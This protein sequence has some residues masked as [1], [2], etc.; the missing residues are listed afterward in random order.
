MVRVL[1]LEDDETFADLLRL[2]LEARG[3]SAEIVHS[4]E[5]A[6]G[7]LT[8]GGIGLVLADVYIKQGGMP[9]PDGGLKLAGMITR[10]RLSPQPPDWAR[11]PIVVM[12]GALRRPGQSELLSMAS[13]LGA[14]GVLAKPFT[15]DE[16]HMEMLRL[17]PEI[18]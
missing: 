14:D 11:V 5:L 2:G 18:D 12:T 8:Q 7:R 10:A 4:S 3:H 15:P 17:M 1:I 9:V 13:S 16:L 6:V